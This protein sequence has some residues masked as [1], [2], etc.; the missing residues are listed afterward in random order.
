MEEIEKNV[1]AENASLTERLSEAVRALR[2]IK[3]GEI[4]SL[5]VTL[6][7]RFEE[8]EETLRAIRAGEID[9]LVIQGVRGEEVL[10]LQGADT[11]YR[12]IFET[13][14][15]AVAVVARGGVILHCN[16]RLGALLKVPLV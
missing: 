11:S 10:T 15:E 3:P 14:N 6:L 5:V 2:S 12:T 9:A 4:D 1:S 13:M 16:A 8:A 7:C